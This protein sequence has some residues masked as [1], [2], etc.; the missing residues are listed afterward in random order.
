MKKYLLHKKFIEDMCQNSEPNFAKR[1]LQTIFNKEDLNSEDHKFKN[2]ENAYIKKISRGDRIIYIK[3]KNSDMIFYRC[4]NHSIE[5]IQDRNKN[6]DINSIIDECS[7]I[8]INENEIEEMVSPQTFLSNHKGKTIVQAFWSR[9]RVPHKEVYIVTPF[10][11]TS[12]LLS[13]S[14]F[15]KMIDDFLSEHTDV[16]L[17]TQIPNVEDIKVYKDFERRGATTWFKEKL[18]TKVYLF[19][20]NKEFNSSYAERDD[21]GIIGSANLTNRGIPFNGTDFN[22]ET[23]YT[24]PNEDI[25]MMK[26][27]V[28]ETILSSQSVYDLRK[29]E[30]I[31]TSK[32]KNIHLRRI[33]NG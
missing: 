20:T 7:E 8:E 28:L 24:V 13:T 16:N 22:H 26:N 10:I 19:I 12:Y 25:N 30:K 21:L 18:H 11:E 5:D 6:V 32:N 29:V 31:L 15:G 23:C 27:T 14:K 2:L 4:G 17:V 9:R 33:N 3:S 1:V